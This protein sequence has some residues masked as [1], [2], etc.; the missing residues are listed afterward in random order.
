[1]IILAGVQYPVYLKGTTF[2]RGWST[3]LYPV[4]ASDD[5]SSIQWHF[6]ES[7]HPDT[8]DLAPKIA[9]ANAATNLNDVG[10]KTM[11][12]ARSLTRYCR[13]ANIYVGTEGFDPQDPEEKSGASP[14]RSKWFLHNKI[15]ASIASSGMGAGGPGFSVK[16]SLHKK[17][18]AVV[19]NM[20]N[21]QHN[22]TVSKNRPVIM[23]DVAKNTGWLIPEICI[24][25]H[26]AYSWLLQHGNLVESEKGKVPLAPVTG[27][28]GEVVEALIEEN[29]HL[30]LKC[31]R[32]NLRR[33][34]YDIIGNVL[35]VLSACGQTQ[36]Q[37]ESSN[38]GRW[39]ASW[40]RLPRLY[41]WDIADLVDTRE[42]TPRKE[43]RI[44]LNAKDRWLSDVANHPYVLVL[45][46]HDIEPPIRIGVSQVDT[47][48]SRQ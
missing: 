22:L 15:T 33:R 44:Y 10:V 42:S 7:D 24:V 3:L 30:K 28:V 9:L 11:Q 20:N 17:A 43:I 2:F 29:K 40:F 13:N 12:N 41:R 16:A 47:D 4:S 45:F 6:V 5:L 34:Y 31:K 32:T 21:P 27:Q 25:L 19:E 26:L 18:R 39:I 37:E 23:Y 35:K 36:L 1:M 48:T 14:V 8:P 38:K 46:C